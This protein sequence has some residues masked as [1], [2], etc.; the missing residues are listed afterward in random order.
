MYH[1]FSSLFHHQQG[2]VM[3]NCICGSPDLCQI[4]EK[5]MPMFQPHEFKPSTRK[6]I[7]HFLMGLISFAL[8]VMAL[9]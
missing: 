2:K 9:V 4:C 5:D 3:K 6:F 7:W 8:M 1:N